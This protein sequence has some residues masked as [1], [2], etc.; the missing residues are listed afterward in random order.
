MRKK[1]LLM[2]LLINLIFSSHA[3][4]KSVFILAEVGD[5]AV[6]NQDFFNRLKLNA[7]INNEV[8]GGQ[9]YVES[10]Y[11]SILEELINEKIYMKTLASMQLPI[12]EQELMDAVNSFFGTFSDKAYE[13]LD[14]RQ[15]VMGDFV[16]KVKGMIA[17]E[18]IKD[19]I[20]IPSIVVDNKFVDEKR[21]ELIG[22]QKIQKVKLL[23]IVI[24]IALDNS[25]QRVIS[26]VMKELSKGVAFG[27]IAKKYSSALSAEDEGNI[28][29]L[30]SGDLSEN[31]SNRINKLDIGEYTDPIFTGESYKVI[32]VADRLKLP[33]IKK[34]DLAKTVVSLKHIFVA[35]E[36]IVNKVRYFKKKLQ[37]IKKYI[38]DCKDVSDLG[39]YIETKYQVFDMTAQ[40]KSFD[41]SI[42]SQLYNLRINQPSDV[43]ESEQGLHLVMICKRE[44]PTKVQNKIPEIAEIHADIRNE[45]AKQEMERYIKEIKDRTYIKIREKIE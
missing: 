17:K 9:K 29:W 2:V 6:T 24:P 33:L 4:D 10:K 42:R 22:N 5:S 39:K 15:V 25:H 8:I 30:N 41:N 3:A 20:V 11:Y 40:V 44:F 28:G 21:E 31:I 43:I 14:A 45:L 19:N 13:Y 23:E 26:S 32:Q 1:I 27:K 7:I 38:S 12:T 36:N 35:N 16:E 34:S 37:L 18:K